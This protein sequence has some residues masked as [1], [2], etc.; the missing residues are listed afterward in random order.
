MDLVTQLQT[1][2]H[3]SNDLAARLGQQEDELKVVRE[4]VS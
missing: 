2:E 4:A 3:L 1:A